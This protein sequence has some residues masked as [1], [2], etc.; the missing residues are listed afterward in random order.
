[1]WLKYDQVLCCFYDEDSTSTDSIELRI[2]FCQNAE[3]NQSYF[4]T[5][6]PKSKLCLHVVYHFTAKSV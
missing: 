4:S 5:P 2:A 1:M 6:V 3:I